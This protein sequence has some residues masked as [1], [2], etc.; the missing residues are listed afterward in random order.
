M[1]FPALNAFV[2]KVKN[3][4]D[5]EKILLIIEIIPAY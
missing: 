1:R 3:I 5:R 2:P 4:K